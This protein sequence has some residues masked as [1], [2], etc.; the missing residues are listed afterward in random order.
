MYNF[1]QPKYG[2]Y[3]ASKDWILTVH[4]ENFLNEALKQTGINIQNEGF[5]KLH[6]DFNNF[7]STGHVSEF[8]R[9]QTCLHAYLQAIEFIGQYTEKIASM[10]ELKEHGIIDKIDYD[11]AK[12]E[13]MNQINHGG[14]NNLIL[15]Y[16]P[17]KAQ[18]C[19]NVELSTP[20]DMNEIRKQLFKFN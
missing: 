15:A 6:D 10:S 4:N 2:G 16:N 11:K 8:I 3:N 9:N 13:I 7:L 1:T 14:T 5:S 12:M 17:G 18:V 20:F 19:Q